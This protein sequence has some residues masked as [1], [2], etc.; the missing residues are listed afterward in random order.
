MNCSRMN[1]D[2]AA[3]LLEIIETAQG[4]M[5]MDSSLEHW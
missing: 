4:I 1:G 5:I 2:I 3:G